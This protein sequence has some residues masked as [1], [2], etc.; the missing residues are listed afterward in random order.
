MPKLRL[1]AT[2]ALLVTVRPSML[3][4]LPIAEITVNA[5]VILGM[6]GAVGFLSGLFG[7]GGGFMMT[8]LL[9]FIG[10][11]PAV[12]VGS[13]ANQLVAASLSGVLAHWR[14]G[15]VDVRMGM[16]MLCGSTVGTLV[17]VWVFSLLQALGQIDLAISLSYVVFLT[18]IAA[19]ML[20]ESIRAVLRQ[21][22][23][24]RPK[25]RSHKQ[26][27]RHRLPFKMRF[28]KSKLYISALLPL[29]VGALGGLLV[30]VMGIG[31]GF[32]LVPA[33][34]YLLGMP[35]STV[36]GTSLFQIIFTTGMAT[37]LHAYENQTVD[38][39][40]ALLLLAGGVI[41]AQFGSRVSGVLKGEQARLLL[42]IMV[43]VVSV[44]LAIDLFTP[45]EDPYSI[46]VRAPL[47]SP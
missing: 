16:V 3:V 44:N 32:F 43:L 39:L 22:R 18:L 10:V 13:Q 27:W 34:I 46:E 40:L 9:I 4:H 47:A 7:V 30:A 36:A 29:A 19:L 8:P 38:V 31:G 11:P 21:R 6:G 24:G 15:N 35:V 2:A 41:G 1:R 5:L 14:R 42:A 33:M 23:G 37:F 25:P 45:P 12:A 20:N 17:G 28:Q 26:P